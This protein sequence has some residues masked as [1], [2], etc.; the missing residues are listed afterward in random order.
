MRRSQWTLSLPICDSAAI[1]AQTPANSTQ[2][3]AEPFVAIE[4]LHSSVM[5][6]SNCHKLLHQDDEAKVESH[7]AG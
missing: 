1:E 3:T 5:I 7:A 6:P 2:A 4:R